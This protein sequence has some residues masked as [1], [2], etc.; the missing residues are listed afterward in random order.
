[1]ILEYSK[2]YSKISILI[3]KLCKF[4][5][6]L[7]STIDDLSNEFVRYA[8]YYDKIK[9]DI[10]YETKIHFQG[11]LVGPALAALG[12]NGKVE[13]YLKYSSISSMDLDNYP[14]LD[15]LL[16]IFIQSIS[17]TKITI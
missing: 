6:K 16:S 10:P 4:R 12:M 3:D 7:F 1:M 11:L 15:L 13:E 9:N 14:L 17:Q 2:T 5:Y 8:N